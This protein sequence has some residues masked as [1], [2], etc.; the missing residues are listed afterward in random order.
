VELFVVRDARFYVPLSPYVRDQLARGNY[1]EL[2]GA[3][4]EVL[5]DLRACEAVMTIVRAEEYT[6]RGSR[7]SSVSTES[8]A[9]SDDDGV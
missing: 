7:C 5:R 3:R 1:A 4:F 2:V 6:S 9:S 8:E